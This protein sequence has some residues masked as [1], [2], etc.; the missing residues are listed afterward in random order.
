MGAS[1]H[2]SQ[3]PTLWVLVGGILLVTVAALIIAMAP[4][5]PC[6]VCGGRNNEGWAQIHIQGMRVNVYCKCRPSGGKVSLFKRWTY[7]PDGYAQ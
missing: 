6:P 3:G 4:L 2:S 5:V 7:K 1:D